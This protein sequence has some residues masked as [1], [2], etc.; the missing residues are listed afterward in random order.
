MAT[1]DDKYTLP[2]E[3]GSLGLVAYPDYYVAPTNTTDTSVTSSTAGSFVYGLFGP[4][5]PSPASLY[6]TAGRDLALTTLKAGDPLGYVFGYTTVVPKIITVHEDGD[7]L[8]VDYFLSVGECQEIVSVSRSG[9]DIGKPSSW[10]YF[11]G[12]SSQTASTLMS[13]VLGS[14]D[15]LPNICHVVAKLTAKTPI[16]CRF[17]VK[18]LKLADPRNSPETTAYSTNPALAIARMLEDCGYTTDRASVATAANFCD[19]SV[20]GADRWTINMQC[21]DRRSVKVWA[22]A[23]AQYANCFIDYQGGVVAIYPDAQVTTSPQITRTISASDMVEGS[24]K[25]SI[26]GTRQTPEQVTVIYRELDGTQL[27]ATAGAGSTGHRTTML[28]PGIQ[29]YSE[30]RRKAEEVLAKAQRA[31]THEHISFDSGLSDSVGDLMRITYS[32]HNLSSKLMRLIGLEEVSRGR[33]KRAFSEYEDADYNNS[34]YVGPTRTT[35]TTPSAESIPDGPTPTLSQALVT[36]A[37]G[38]SQYKLQIEFHGI[39]WAKTDSYR[40][41]ISEDAV[42]QETKSVP[43]L[44]TAIAVGAPYIVLSTDAIVA[45]KEYSVYVWVRSTN[46]SVSETPGYATFTPTFGNRAELGAGDLTNMHEYILDGDGRY[47]TT[48]EK[49]GSPQLGET[50]SSRFSASPI[51]AWSAGETWLGNQ[52]CE[53]V[54]QTEVWDSGTTWAGLWRWAKF[55]Y[56]TEL[57]GATSGDYVSLSDAVSPL[58]FTDNAGTSYSDEAQYMKAKCVVSDSPLSA[59]MGLHVKLPISVTMGIGG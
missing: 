47:A 21:A 30:A 55:G 38:I 18:G 6:S 52:I 19:E 3:E 54:F 15:A 29:T 51:P 25:T 40:V 36:D 4:N 59:G 58:S 32:P 48:S 27:P 41:Q 42:Y 1:A 2:Y 43:Y 37:S 22:S 10:E 50:W 34:T 16:D 33:W 53:T 14:Y 24:A 35:T 5:K 20:G 39:T 9:K 57:G 23:L 12:T 28:M 49:T 7:Y 8:Y 13:G 31:T 26:A 46:G 11:L 17:V 56:V 44:P 45:G